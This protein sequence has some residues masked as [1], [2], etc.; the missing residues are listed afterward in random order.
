MYCIVCC[1]CRR[2]STRRTATATARSTSRSSCASWRRRRSTE[3]R[4]SSTRIAS[5]RLCL[6]SRLSFFLLTQSISCV[7]WSITCLAVSFQ[8]RLPHD[9]HSL[10]FPSRCTFLSIKPLQ[11]YCTL[12]IDS[13]SNS[14][15][16]YFCYMPLYSTDREFVSLK[17]NI[18][19]Y[20]LRILYS[21]CD[22][23]QI[24]CPWTRIIF[25]FKT[26]N[27]ILE[28]ESC[29][30]VLSLRYVYC[31]ISHTPTLRYYFKFM[32]FRSYVNRTSIGQ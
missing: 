21:S 5:L 7:A 8:N 32:R 12:W 10:S 15:L 14:F 31:F 26:E 4:T 3:Q 24:D 25:L 28:F 19:C 1:M 11:L 9:T 23:F 22:R 18:V 20:Y 29:L 17:V 2:W 13:I 30:Q 27:A 16:L 6:A